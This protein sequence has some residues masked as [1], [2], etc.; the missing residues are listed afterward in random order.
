MFDRVR[1]RIL[2]ERR[3][4]AQLYFRIESRNG[5]YKNCFA[6]DITGKRVGHHVLHE[7]AGH[8]LLFGVTFFH[9]MIDRTFVQPYIIC[10]TGIMIAIGAHIQA[11]IK[12]GCEQ[13]DKNAP[14]VHR[15]AK[16]G[17]DAVNR[18]YDQ[19]RD[20]AHQIAIAVKID[21]AEA[22]EKENE[23]SQAG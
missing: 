10:I 15:L 7:K 20:Q 4:N 18:K 5:I 1:I 14:F 11:I 9:A 6:V 3:K 23:Y 22:E 13:H 12:T 19:R 8:K 17:I 2:L 16:N 21:R